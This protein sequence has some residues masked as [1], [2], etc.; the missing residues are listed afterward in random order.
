MDAVTDL[1]SNINL[2]QFDVRK[3]FSF[4]VTHA[5]VLKALHTIEQA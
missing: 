1:L 3:D 5:A 4:M 2:K